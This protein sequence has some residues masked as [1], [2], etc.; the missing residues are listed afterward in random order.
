[1][2][3]GVHERGPLPGHRYVGFVDPSGGSSDSFT[4][5]IAH[6]ENELGVLDAL[7]EVIPPFSPEGVTTEFADLCKR[8]RITEVRGDRYGGEWPREQ[9]RKQ[10]ITYEL[11]DHAKGLLYLNTLPLLNSAKVRLLDNKR[12]VSQLVG[13]ERTT[14]RGGRDSIDHARGGHDDVANACAGA[15]LLATAR[16]PAIRTGF[17]AA[18]I[19]PIDWGEENE[20]PQLRVQRITQ[21]EMDAEGIRAVAPSESPFQPKKTAQFRLRSS[22][23]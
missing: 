10:G 4:L 12:L 8:Y 22:R 15:L 23:R 20:Q 7:R 2:D 11:S 17:C 21:A 14:A 13:L 5:A 1:M 18:G 19:G 9:F 16:L 6:K 3:W